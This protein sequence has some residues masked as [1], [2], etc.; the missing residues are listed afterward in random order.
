MRDWLGRDFKSHH[1]WG[2]PVSSCLPDFLPFLSPHFLC[3]CYRAR[4]LRGQ[5][6]ASLP[7]FKSCLTIS[8]GPIRALPWEFSNWSLMVRSKVIPEFLEKSTMGEERVQPSRNRRRNAWQS[9]RSSGPCSPGPWVLW[10]C[11]TASTC[12]L[13]RVFPIPA[14]PPGG[15]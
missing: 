4:H 14:R 13:S 6:G 9:T 8:A 12:G 1:P 3:R 5:F 15:T 7:G 10:C 11:G 2:D